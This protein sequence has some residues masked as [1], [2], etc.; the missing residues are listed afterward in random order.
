MAADLYQALERFLDTQ[1]TLRGASPHTLRAYENDLIQ[2]I[3]L[4]RARGVRD[5]GGVD[6]LVV[7]EFIRHYREGRDG[8]GARSKSTMARKVSA[9]RTFFR[10]LVEQDELE[11]NP[12]V[13]VRRP[14]RDRPLPKFLDEPAI[15]RLLDAPAGDSFAA[16]RDRALLEVLYSTGARVSEVVS[17]NVD[18]V[19]RLGRTMRVRGKRKKER[20]LILGEPSVAALTVYLDRRAER[21]R[22]MGRSTEPALFLNDRRGP[23]GLRRL[24][25]RSM[26]R[27][28]KVHLAHADLDPSASP[29]TLRHSFAT[30]LLNRGANLRV[31]QEFLGHE[32]LTTTQI[33]THLDLERL[34]KTYDE[35]HPR[36]D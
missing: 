26:R 3:E 22:A 24:T 36:A 29:H 13:P 8:D 20:M 27:L 14:K 23:A 11:E 9:L 19:D 10:F 7:R 28:L 1:R 33:Y 35:T 32:N 25:D 15:D 12:A 4:A 5:A 21:L 2:F 30:H 16:V 31:V 6:T 34:K 17:A 18:D